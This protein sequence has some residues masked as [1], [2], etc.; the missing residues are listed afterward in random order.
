MSSLA[1][2]VTSIPLTGDEE[3]ALAALVPFATL[4]SGA[5]ATV[6]AEADEQVAPGAGWQPSFGLDTQAIFVVILAQLTVSFIKALGEDSGK[7]FWDGLLALHRK[8]AERFHVFPL[9]GL[10]TR[11]RPRRYKGVPVEIVL[12]LPHALYTDPTPLARVI[13]RAW[14]SLPQ[15]ETAAEALID[16]AAAT[17]ARKR[18]VIHGLV[19][20]GTTA[21]SVV[22]LDDDVP[23]P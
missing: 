3:S 5:L 2:V 22:V 14:A 17:L 12:T 1:A 20:G 23:L 9:R 13:R 8:V 15:Y 19:H 4:D 10:Q 11:L 6:P 7:K 21:W 18:V 16:A